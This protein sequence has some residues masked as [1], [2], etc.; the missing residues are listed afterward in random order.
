MVCSRQFLLSGAGGAYFPCEVVGIHLGGKALQKVDIAA[1]CRFHLIKAAHIN[2]GFAI[3]AIDPKKLSARCRRR[4]GRA[5][6]KRRT[7]RKNKE[8]LFHG[9]PSFG[10]YFV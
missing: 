7:Q 2:F 6:K 1:S 9:L 8:Y 4:H 5:E 3:G 10:Q